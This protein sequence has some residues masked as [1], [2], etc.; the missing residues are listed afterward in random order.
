MPK[1][2]PQKPDPN[3]EQELVLTLDPATALMLGLTAQP[4]A[5]PVP[6][7]PRRSRSRKN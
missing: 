7:K 5:T 6:D 3:D 2:R 4:R 1:R